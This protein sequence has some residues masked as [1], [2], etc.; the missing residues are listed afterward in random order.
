MPDAIKQWIQR[1][2]VDLV[3]PLAVLG[4]ERT[5]PPI[6]RGRDAQRTTPPF[7]RPHQ[8][9]AVGRRARMGLS[10]YMRRRALGG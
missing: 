7:D 3:K 1:R 2:V 8:E 6:L 5:E 4:D 10:P 9:H